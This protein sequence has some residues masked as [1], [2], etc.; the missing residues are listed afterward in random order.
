MYLAVFSFKHQSIYRNSF[1]GS[2]PS[3][4]WQT[5][6]MLVVMY[7]VQIEADRSTDDP[8]LRFRMARTV[9]GTAV[10]GLI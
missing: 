4:W 10:V 7:I 1:V 8:M 9:P 2:L 6:D 5:D 3:G